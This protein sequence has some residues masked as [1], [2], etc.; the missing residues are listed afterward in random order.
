MYVAEAGVR[1]TLRTVA[2]ISAP[3]S[4]LVMDYAARA[5]LDIIKQMPNAPQVKYL[6]GWNEP[7]VFGVPEGQEREF[8]A[9]VG[10]EAVEFLPV[11]GRESF[12]RYLKRQDGTIYGMPPNMQP[13]AGPPPG[14]T[15]VGATAAARN[16]T[17]YSLV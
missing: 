2:R 3:G 15:S 10:L 5:V 13:P 11:F 9:E 17:F 4:I 14:A 8:F 1:E 12:V 6:S 16:V 7:W